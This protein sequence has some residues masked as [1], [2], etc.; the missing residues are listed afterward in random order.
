MENPDLKALATLL[1]VLCADMVEAAGS[2]HPGMPMGMADVATVLFANHLTFDPQA[3]EWPGRDRFVLSAGHGSAL[4]YALLHLVGVEA[5]TLDQLRALRRKGS[6]TPGHPEFGHTP[7]IEC[8]TGPL[9][10][11]LATAVGMAIAGRKLAAEVGEDLAGHTVYVIAGDGC[12]ME[13]ISHEAGALAGHLGLR[14]LVV[15]FDNNGISIDGPVSLT[16]SEDVRARFAA[17]GW[18]VLA[19]DGHDHAAIDAALHAAKGHDRPTL[20]ACRTRIGQGAPSKGGGSGVHG[21][22]LGAAEV[23]AMRAALGWVHAPFDLPAGLV[24][25]WRAAGQHGAQARARWQQRFDAADGAVQARLSAVAARRVPQGDA[26]LWQAVR[27]RALATERPEAT[28]VSSKNVL[29]QLVPACPWLLGGSADLSGSNGTRTAAHQ[30]FTA[31]HPQGNYLRYGIRENA[32]A[33]AMNGIALS[34]AYVPYGGT[35]LVFSDYSRPA[36]RLS[37]LMGLRTVHVLT[38]DSIGLGEDGPTHQPI[39][40][41]A[42]L[43]L[44]PGLRLFRPADAIET[45]EC[46]ELALAHD[47]PAVLALSRQDLPQLRRD[48]ATNRSAAGAYCLAEAEGTRRVTLIATGSEVHLALAARDEL[49][50]QGIGA[51]VISAPCLELLADQGEDTVEALLQRRTSLCVSVEAAAAAPWRAWT[52]LDGINLGIDGFGESASAA[53]LYAQFG[54]TGEAIAA[55]ITARLLERLALA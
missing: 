27:E 11:G 19:V 13:G 51:A 17:Y 47:G 49:A 46:W 36:L 14:N 39:E 22:P 53:Q 55:R 31:D 37:A 4:A 12:L 40:H 34:G 15:L 1:R 6:L 28:R 54:L 20:I 25:Q 38:H 5:M 3:P 45:A 30:D 18:D 35:F 9:G 10:Q 29:E 42:S 21:S 50:R 8:T 41:V 24:A 23:T 43:R 2:G 33:A 44:I 7:G 26:A 48:I 32:M 16:T 52:G